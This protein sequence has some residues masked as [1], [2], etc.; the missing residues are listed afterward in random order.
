M[1][2]ICTYACIW[3]SSTHYRSIDF[4]Y[5]LAFSIRGGGKLLHACY[6][7]NMSDSSKCA[8]HIHNFLTPLENVTPKSR[9]NTSLRKSFMKNNNEFLFL[10]FNTEHPFMFKAARQVPD[11]SLCLHWRSSILQSQR[12]SGTLFRVPGWQ[13]VLS[14]KNQL[15]SFL[16]VYYI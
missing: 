13:N 11:Y 10:Q 4:M 8:S 14:S 1:H 16:Y 7:L 3:N 5:K 12:S 2:L 6:Y 15:I 9:I